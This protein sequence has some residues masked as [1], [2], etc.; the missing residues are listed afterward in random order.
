MP[1]V[2]AEKTSRF[3]GVGRRVISRLDKL[4]EEKTV[5]YS[6]YLASIVF[7]LGIILFPSLLGILLKLDTAMNVVSNPELLNRSFSAVFS[8]IIMAGIVSA[9]DVAAGLPLAW[10]I[11]RKKYRWLN[12]VDSLV[13]FPLIVPTVILGYST[14]LLWCEETPFSIIGFTGVSPGFI[15]VLLL[16]FAFSYPVVVRILAGKLM[17]I[18]AT[19]EVAAR[20]LG[21]CPFT[22]ART[23][24]IPM[25]KSGIIASL[26][27]SFA[28]SLSETGATIM[29]AGSFENGPVF[30]KKSID[31]GLVPPMVFVSLVLIVL[32]IL[33]LAGLRLFGFKFRMPFRKAYRIEAALS[34]EGVTRVRDL[35]A[36]IIFLFLVLLPACFMVLARMPLMLSYGLLGE[37][38][39]LRGAWSTYWLSVLNSYVIALLT[40]LINVVFSLPMAVIIVR[41]KLGGLVSRLLEALSTTSII[42]PSVALGVSLSLFW[43][44]SGISD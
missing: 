44:A 37:I 22:T 39:T 10:I 33:I 40:T 11:A 15:T 26:I 25:L 6:L 16:H 3:R 28:R 43:G 13:D 14:L 31:A 23:I 30:I 20:T 36:I 8:S 32:S 41:R 38:F 4:S 18:E 21:A 5:A 9:L 42:M 7:F 35:S 1:A 24:T 12:I 2:E 27:L 19:Y 34:R 29:V 17:D